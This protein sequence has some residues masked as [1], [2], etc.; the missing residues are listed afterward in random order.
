M[1][2]DQG[3]SLVGSRAG[4]L[5]YLDQMHAWACSLA[6]PGHV[7]HK[8]CTAHYLCTQSLGISG[9]VEVSHNV[10]GVSGG[11]LFV[12]EGSSASIQV[13]GPVVLHSN[14]AATFGGVLQVSR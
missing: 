10:A 4:G 8:H 11:V 9:A 13:T 3:G 5:L 6:C 12:G 14:K 1:A 2:V 7:K